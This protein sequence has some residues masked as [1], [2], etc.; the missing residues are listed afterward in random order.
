AFLIGQGEQGPLHPV[1]RVL[2]ADPE[3]PPSGQL[4]QPLP[5]RAPPADEIHGPACS[6]ARG[7]VCRGRRP[8]GPYPS[9]SAPPP[10][11]TWLTA[12]GVQD[13]QIQLI[14]G[15][16][17]WYRTTMSTWIPWIT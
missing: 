5:I 2:P 15:H 3:V 17:S 6:A 1:A 14:S 12:Q 11:L 7:G 8:A 13:T 4:G 16:S 9:S 10:D